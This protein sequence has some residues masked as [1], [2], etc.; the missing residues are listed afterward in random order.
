MQRK[1]VF[2]ILVL[3]SLLIAPATS[4]QAPSNAWRGAYFANRDLQ[5]SPALVRDDP[6]LLFR[7]GGGSPGPNIPGDNW[8]ARWQRTMN[9]AAGDYTFTAQ[10]DDGVRLFVDNTPVINSW[11][12]GSFRTVSGTIRGVAAG[13]HTVTVEYFQAG[14]DSGIA[15]SA[16]QAGPSTATP[17]PPAPPPPPPV[18]FPEWRGDYFNDI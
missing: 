4:A 14:G 6:E 1:L 7:W 16:G 15:V 8:S 9:F 3:L 5:G 10:V 11:Q 18:S 12:E 13:A 2:S 17:V